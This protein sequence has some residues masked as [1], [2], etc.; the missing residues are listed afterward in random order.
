MYF[1]T[2]RTHYL[3]HSRHTIWYTADTLFGTQQTHYWVHSRHTISRA[4]SVLAPIQQTAWIL[5][6]DECQVPSAINGGWFVL[7]KKRQVHQQTL[8]T[9]TT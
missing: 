8:C 4:S 1:G 7:C 5:H 2:Q 9:P 6:R 3:V